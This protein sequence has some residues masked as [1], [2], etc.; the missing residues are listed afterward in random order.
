MDF[1]YQVFILNSNGWWV[2]TDNLLMAQARAEELAEKEGRPAYVVDTTHGG[3]IYT[4]EG[5]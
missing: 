4:A 1:K 3:I 5:K 2:C